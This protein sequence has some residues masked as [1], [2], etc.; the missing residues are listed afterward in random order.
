MTAAAVGRVFQTISPIDGTVVVERPF[1]S[2][3][4]IDA[5][6]ARAAEAQR[7]WARVPVAERAERCTKAIEW[8]VD[9]ADQLGAELT[10]Q[11]G[12]PIAHSPL[13][14]TRGFQER[15]RYLAHVAASALADIEVERNGEFHKFIRRVPL[16]VALVLAPWNYPWLTS[17][18]A[19][20]AALLAGNAVILK[21]SE[22]TP[23]V[24]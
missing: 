17:E 19:V 22:Q 13:E 24:A 18:N 8:C 5:A 12:R 7:G 11:M 4:E 3:A 16:G 21:M 6:V 15:G 2:D 9:R 20:V 1:A 23:L 14:I 10:A